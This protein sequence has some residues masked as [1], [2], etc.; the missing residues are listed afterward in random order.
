MRGPSLKQHTQ[1]QKVV[2]RDLRVARRYRELYAFVP[3]RRLDAI[4]LGNADNGYE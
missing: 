2:V 4:E 3:R 1:W